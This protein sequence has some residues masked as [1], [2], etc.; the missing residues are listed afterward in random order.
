MNAL[1]PTTTAI[2]LALWAALPVGSAMAA[3]AE[4]GAALAEQWCNACHSINSPEVRQADAGPRFEEL[5]KQ[6][7]AFI[8]AALNRPHDFMPEFPKLTDADKADLAAYIQ[9]LR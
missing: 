9:S 1:I 2:G 7:Q 8:L 3:D 4:N 6:D 5:A